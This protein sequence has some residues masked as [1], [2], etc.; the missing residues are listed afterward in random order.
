MLGVRSSEIR[1]KLIL[2]GSDLTLAKYLDI[3]HTYELSLP[4]AQAIANQTTNGAVEAITH[5]HGCGR[6]QGKP[7]GALD[8]CGNNKHKTKTDYPA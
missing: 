4:Q 1:K 7:R 6:A 8:N 3:V 5:N 2:E